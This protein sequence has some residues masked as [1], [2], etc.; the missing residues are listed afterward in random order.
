MPEENTE[1]T[2]ID[3]PRNPLDI[4]AATCLR[5]REFTSLMIR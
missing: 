1:N 4:K 2:T 3:A 5:V